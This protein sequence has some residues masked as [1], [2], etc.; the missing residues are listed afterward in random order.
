LRLRIDVLAVQRK[1][2]SQILGP[3]Q[4]LRIIEG[5]R[6]IL[7][8][9]IH[10]FFASHFAASMCN[11]GPSLKSI[12]RY[13]C[14]RHELLKRELS[15]F[16]TPFRKVNFERVGARHDHVLQKAFYNNGSIALAAAIC[17]ILI[18]IP[19]ATKSRRSLVTISCRS[20][21]IVRF[22]DGKLQGRGPSIGSSPP[23]VVVRAEPAWRRGPHVINGT[24]TNVAS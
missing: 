3:Q 18:F 21:L 16:K 10:D 14:D 4:L 6:H 23:I 22:D 7:F 20:E 17:F 5:V 13:F 2:G 19:N 15:L 11:L 12:Y 9:E 1:Q 8:S 24:P